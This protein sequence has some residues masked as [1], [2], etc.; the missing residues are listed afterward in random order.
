MVRSLIK[1]TGLCAAL[2]TGSAFAQVATIAQPGNIVG[3]FQ[4]QNWVNTLAAPTTLYTVPTGK[5]ARITD[6]IVWGGDIAAGRTCSIVLYC[7]NASGSNLI[8]VMADAG[9]STLYNFNNGLSCK[10]PGKFVSYSYNN[11]VYTSATGCG[12]GGGGSNTPWLILRGFL[13]TNPV[14]PQ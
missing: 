9:K 8:Y 4:G 12:D 10:A 2:A 3:T 13:Y 14:S 5:S 1:A 11:S 7:S 6:L